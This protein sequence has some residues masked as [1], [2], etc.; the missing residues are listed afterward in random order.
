[1]KDPIFPSVRGQDQPVS[2]SSSR[3]FE[4]LIFGEVKSQCNGDSPTY[5]ETISLL[6]LVAKAKRD[7]GRISKKPNKLLKKNM[8]FFLVQKTISSDVM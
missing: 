1:M 3:S 8:P 5:C 4:N 6:F 2:Q 7:F